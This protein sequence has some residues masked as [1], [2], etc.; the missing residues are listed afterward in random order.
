MWSGRKELV[1]C[2]VSRYRETEERRRSKTSVGDVNV[3]W[4]LMRK[5]S[6]ETYLA[7]KERM[8]K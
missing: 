6:C 4:L 8:E 2:A 5:A 1:C 3:K 7:S